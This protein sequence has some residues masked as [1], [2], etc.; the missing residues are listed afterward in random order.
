MKTPNEYY[1]SINLNMSS[2]DGAQ[3]NLNTSFSRRVKVDSIKDLI[4][5]LE[6]FDQVTDN[7]NDILNV[8]PAE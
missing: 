6:K 5:L 7:L 2:V 8:L 4:K 3:G 1:V